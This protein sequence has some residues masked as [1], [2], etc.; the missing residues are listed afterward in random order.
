MKIKCES[1]KS[2]HIPFINGVEAILG[3]YIN[4]EFRRHIHNT[5]IIG[6]VEQGKRTIT[7]SDG[8]AQVSVNEIF[9]LNPGQVH[10]CS[11]EG[12]SG[13]SYKIL[14]I[15]P[16]TMQAIISQISEK[17][18]KRPYFN[19]N[20]FKHDTLSKKIIQLFDVIEEPD[21]DIQV[22]SEIYSFLAYL[23]IRFSEFPPSVCSAGAHKGAIKRVCEYIHQNVSKNL[24]LKKLAEIACLSPFHFQREFKKSIGITP[25]EYLSDTKISASK[26]MLLK[27]EDIAD[28]ANRLGFF[29]QS[30]FSRIFR[31]TVGI[32]P[33]K[34]SKINRKCEQHHEIHPSETATL[35]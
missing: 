16:Q 14:S 6:I 3:R 10:S 25:H 7:L 24:S 1:I 19:K 2:F 27:S 15:L 8:G 32:P 11:S 13:H 31:K 9:I 12:Q 28:T 35:K 18:R 26:K 17:Q 4:N 20:H 29:D 5:Y 23:L 33:G 21:S 22:E 30:H 34:Y